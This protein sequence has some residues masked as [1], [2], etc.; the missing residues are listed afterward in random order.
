[1]DI[2]PSEVI[3]TPESPVD[4]AEISLQSP[5]EVSE[6]ETLRGNGQ[7]EE[8]TGLFKIRSQ[9]IVVCKCPT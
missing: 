3:E 4:T 1:M 7:F 2:E 9:Q 6:G 8:R 5:V